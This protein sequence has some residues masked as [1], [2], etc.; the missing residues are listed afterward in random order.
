MPGVVFGAC[1]V[2]IADG[3]Q[4]PLKMT[5]TMMMMMLMWMLLIVRMKSHLQSSLS[6]AQHPLN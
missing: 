6:T 3:H 4:Q 5:A 2:V 1:C